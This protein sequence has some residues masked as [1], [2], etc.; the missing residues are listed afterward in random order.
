MSISQAYMLNQYDYKTVRMYEL[1]TDPGQYFK[2]AYL[3]GVFA[4]GYRLNG[5]GAEEGI[6]ISLLNKG[7]S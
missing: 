7:V 6:P 4:W 3:N 2:V 1:K 5:D